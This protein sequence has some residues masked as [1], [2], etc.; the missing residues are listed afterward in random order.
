MSSKNVAQSDIG[1]EITELLLCSGA[2]KCRKLYPLEQIADYRITFQKL[3]FQ[4]TSAL[5]M[6]GQLVL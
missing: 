6:C 3:L 2:H 4:V 1:D 5:L